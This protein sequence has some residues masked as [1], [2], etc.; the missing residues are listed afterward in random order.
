M[1]LELDRLGSGGRWFN[2]FSYKDNVGERF[3]GL[4]L[5]RTQLRLRTNVQG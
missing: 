3:T 4:I 1:K 2:V 5:F